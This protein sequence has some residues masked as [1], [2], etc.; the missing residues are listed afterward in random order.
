MSLSQLLNQ[1][2]L[3]RH[4]TSKSEIAE[5]F[6]LIKRD[7]QDSK[8]KGLSSDR[9]FAT[10]Y[11]AVLQLATIFIY[12][13][14]YRTDGIGHHATVFKAMKELLEEKHH[15]LADYFDSCRAKRNITDYSHAGMVSEKEAE[16]LIGEAE[17]FLQVTLKW[18]KT[19]HPNLI[20]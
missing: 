3:R 6:Q 15:S 16:E 9:R 1:G 4:R 20:K 7:I 12:C 17:K 5:L 18:L 14:G 13:K 2:R 11:N 8:V 10:A 19:N